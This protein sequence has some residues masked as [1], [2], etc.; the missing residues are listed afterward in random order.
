MGMATLPLRNTPLEQLK[1]L[2]AQN[3]AA[4]G[5][6]YRPL[7]KNFQDKEG[8]GIGLCNQISCVNKDIDRNDGKTLTKNHQVHK[9]LNSQ[10]K[11]AK[12]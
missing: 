8:R 3:L 7:K 12:A 4:N 11:G 2:L 1:R 9:Q 5:T 10:A 6:H